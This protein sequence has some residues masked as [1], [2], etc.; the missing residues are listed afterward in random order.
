M[1]R[2]GCQL[3]VRDPQS[4]LLL[5]LLARAHRHTAILRTIS[6]DTSDVFA[7]ASRLAPRPV[8]GLSGDCRRYAA[9]GM[10]PQRQLRNYLLDNRECWTRTSRR[11]LDV[12]VSTKAT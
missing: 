11:Y 5:P 10:K 9:A 3:G 4:L 7:H 6:V 1:P 2:C 12:R 8:M